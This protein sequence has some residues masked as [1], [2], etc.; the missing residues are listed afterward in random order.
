MVVV[1]ICCCMIVGIGD[2]VMVFL[3]IVSIVDCFVVIDECGVYFMVKV[4]KCV[5]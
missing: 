3:L 5:G 1:L 2:I 4:V